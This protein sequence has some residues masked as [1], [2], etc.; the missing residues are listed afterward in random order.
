MV[1][2]NWSKKKDPI[3]GTGEVKG[4]SGSRLP[5]DRAHFDNKPKLGEETVTDLN[6]RNAI[7]VAGGNSPQWRGNVLASSES[8]VLRCGK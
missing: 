6:L 8:T 2:Q 1:T 7:C 4:K 3:G 5:G